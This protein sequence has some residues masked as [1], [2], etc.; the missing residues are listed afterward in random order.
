MKQPDPYNGNSPAKLCL[1]IQQC[2][3]IF[4][5]DPSTFYN[6]HWKVIYAL[7]YLTGK[8]FEWIQPA[9]NNVKTEDPDFIQNSWEE[10]KTQ[11]ALIFGD[12]N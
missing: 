9:L 7:S 12:P 2:K 6:S 3:L 8:A 1:F 11:I 4:Q 10:F 5:N